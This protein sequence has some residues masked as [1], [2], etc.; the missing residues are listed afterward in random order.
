MNVKVGM[1]MLLWGGQIGTEHIP[2]FES[3]REVGYDGVEI[4]VSGQSSAELEKMAAACDDLGLQRTASA[5]VGLESNPISSD[6][7]IRAAA[8][9]NLKQSIDGAYLI[10]AEILIGGI[11]AILPNFKHLGQLAAE[12]VINGK[13]INT[14]IDYT[15]IE[16]KS[17]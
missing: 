4:P 1:N 5:F 16:R 6:S 15:I 13:Q 17:L 10:G 14:N 3:L 8:L 12:V 9:E 2:V 7:A 11:T